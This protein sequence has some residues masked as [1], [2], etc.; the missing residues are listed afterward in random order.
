MNQDSRI[1]SASPEAGYLQKLKE[2]TLSFQ[3]CQACATS[4]FYPRLVCPHCGSRQ[5]SWETSRRFGTVYAVTEL[6]HRDGRSSGVALVTLDE[7]FRIMAG[8]AI[9]EPQ[10][11]LQIGQA[12]KVQVAIDDEQ[13]KLFVE[14]HLDG[15][16]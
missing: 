6:P 8:F 10:D 14:R 4:V 3:R 5:L 15:S 11:R 1:P 12:V 7:G 2:G 13:P 16:H 9:F